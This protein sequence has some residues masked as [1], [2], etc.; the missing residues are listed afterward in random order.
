MNVDNNYGAV[1]FCLVSPLLWV[2]GWHSWFENY[3]HINTRWELKIYLC[4][5]FKG[6]FSNTHALSMLA[7][8][9]LEVDPYFVH[10]SLVQQVCGLRWQS[11]LHFSVSQ[12]NNLIDFLVQRVS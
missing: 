7:L 2:V 11:E 5:Y 1:S 12:P 3:F 6:D 10:V 8:Q 4:D 9:L